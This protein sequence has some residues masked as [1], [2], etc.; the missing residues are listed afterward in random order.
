MKDLFPRISFYITFLFVLLV[1][2]YISLKVIHHLGFYQRGV[3]KT[4]GIH[5]FTQFLSFS[6]YTQRL[7]KNQ[8][9]GTYIKEHF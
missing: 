5:N 9:L 2:E 1:L 6:K 3:F 8:Y 4:I 7:N